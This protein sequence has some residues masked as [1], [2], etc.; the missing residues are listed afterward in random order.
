MVIFNECLDKSVFVSVV[1]GKIPM[2]DHFITQ[3][4][5]IFRISIIWT[6][7]VLLTKNIKLGMLC[8]LVFIIVEASV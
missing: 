4:F 5:E 7:L 3:C 6:E 2:N 1:P 8:N